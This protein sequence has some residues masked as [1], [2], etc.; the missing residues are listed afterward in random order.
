[1]SRVAKEIVRNN[2][3]SGKVTW[4]AYPGLNRRQT[5]KGRKEIPE[6]VGC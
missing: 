3:V 6:G 1:M 4:T 5:A 2:L